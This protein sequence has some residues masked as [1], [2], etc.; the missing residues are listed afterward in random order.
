MKTL[1]WSYLALSIL[2][3]ALAVVLAFQ[4]HA[5]WWSA[6]AFIF[7]AVGLVWLVARFFQLA[8]K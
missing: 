8:K 3:Y 1:A 6:A 2:C 5:P 4:E 7:C